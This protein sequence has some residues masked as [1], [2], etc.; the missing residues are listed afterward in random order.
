[1]LP[2]HLVKFIKYLN[3]KDLTVRTRST[4]QLHVK[5]YLLWLHKEKIIKLKASDLVPVETLIK[6]PPVVPRPLSPEVDQQIQDLLASTQDQLYQA[7]LLIRRTGLRVKELQLM[8]FDCIDYDLKGRATLK[9]PAVKLGIERKVPLDPATIGIIHY[10]QKVSKSYHLK[11]SPPNLLMLNKRGGPIQYMHFSNALTEICSRLN[12]K[13]W[14]TLH[15]LR[16]TYATSLLSAG[17]TITSLKEILGHK[18]ITMSLGYAKV[19]PEKV[20]SEYIKALDHMNNQQIAHLLLPKE[21]SLNESFAEIHR[22]LTK[23]TELASKE[24]KNVINKLLNRL[25]KIKMEI[26]NLPS[27]AGKN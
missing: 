17:L 9:V 6:K 26:R 24:E 23:A 13:K 14:V 18:S 12:L 8:P 20:H 19:T 4:T 22:L 25:S 5:S 27:M 16:H 7:I 1:M 2:E 10:L 3:V 15:T 11:K 21:N